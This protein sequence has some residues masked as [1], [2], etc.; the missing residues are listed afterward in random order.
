MSPNNP[1]PEHDYDSIMAVAVHE[2]VHLAAGQINS[3][4]PAYIAEGLATYLAG[5][6]ENVYDFI[7]SDL[8]SGDFPTMAQIKSMVGYQYS[9]ALTD[10][11][12]S[13]YGIGHMLELYKT[14]DFKK[15][16]GVDDEEF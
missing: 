4:A 11:I 10:Y 12:M 16:F 2:F 7:L 15:T 6:G 9:Y 3:S 1:G 5:Q 13:K 14:A 8:K